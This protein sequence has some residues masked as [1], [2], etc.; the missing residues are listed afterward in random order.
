MWCMLVVDNTWHT[1]TMASATGM[2]TYPF[3][4]AGDCITG[5]LFAYWCFYHK[6]ITSAP[7]FS[8]IH[9][10][11]LGHDRRVLC[12]IS[13]DSLGMYCCTL[14]QNNAVLLIITQYNEFEKTSRYKNHIGV[15]KQR[16]LPCLIR[17]NCK[18]CCL[19]FIYSLYLQEPAHL[20]SYNQE[21]TILQLP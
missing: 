1:S 10:D 15:V 16:G 12:N 9:H 2:H 20:T 5:I 19:Q 3:R 4:W 18:V 7:P 17:W 21:R 14:W 8:S 13:K 6:V 11:P